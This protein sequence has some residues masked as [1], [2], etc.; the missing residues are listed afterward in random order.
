[1]KLLT[2]NLKAYAKINLFLKV[3][4]KEKKYH[5][6]QSVFLYPEVFDKIEIFET[7]KK[8]E[9][10]FY[11]PFGGLVNQKNNTVLKSIILLKKNKK[12][13]N[14]NFIIKVKKNIPIGSGLG[15]GS[16]D[17]VCV[18]NFLIKYYNLKIKNRDYLKYLRLIGHD[19]QVFNNYK[20]K[21]MNLKKIL[22]F[23]SKKV[24][25]KKV[26]IVY[27][28][29]NISTDIVF[30]KNKVF[31]KIISINE[32][33]NLDQILSVSKYFGNDLERVV[34]KK[35]KQILNLLLYLKNL[36]G[37]TFS[38][39]T[40]SGS[41]CFAFFKDNACLYRAIYNLRKQYKNYWITSAKII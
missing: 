27:P 29:I 7:S 23:K 20:P 31:S 41:A 33:L 38:Q 8:T 40:G 22:T 36:S 39:M 12:F 17:A 4:K 18:F 21:F 15:G 13:K 30:K 35:S 24:L 10:K 3:I 19:A 5:L 28:N 11:G 9:V 25:Q 6:L 1:M 26:L 14:K 16:S 32:N 37:C 34:T 2:R